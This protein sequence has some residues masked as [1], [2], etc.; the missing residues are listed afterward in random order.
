[1]KAFDSVVGSRLIVAYVRSRWTDSGL[2]EPLFLDVPYQLLHQRL[3]RRL[4]IQHRPHVLKSR[5]HLVTGRPSR[6]LYATNVISANLVCELHNC[7]NSESVHCLD[8]YTRSLFM[9]HKY[10]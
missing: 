2:V 1:M 8:V 5:P 7:S 4:V 3:S 10:S 6:L 9:S